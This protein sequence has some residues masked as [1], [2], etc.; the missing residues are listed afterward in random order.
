[1]S[2]FGEVTL[3]E[4]WAMLNACAHGWTRKEYTHFWCVMYGGKTFPNLPKRSEVQVGHVKKM[5][6]HLGI[7]D[8]AKDKLDI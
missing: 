8:C 3:N 4:V 2:S 6:R 1:V 5:A 7:L